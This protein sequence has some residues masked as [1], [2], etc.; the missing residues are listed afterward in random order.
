MVAGRKLFFE[1]T[2][3]SC[4]RC[5][6]VG[7]KFGEATGGEVGPN[8][9]NVAKDKDR[10]YLLES[11]CIPDATI[12][13]GFETV[14][15]ADDSGQVYTGIILAESEELIDLV[16]ADG[17]KRRIPVEQIVA[18]RKGTS[19]MPNDLVKQMTLRELRDLVAF[20]ASLQ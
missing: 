2:Q 18:R 13:K 14:V 1:K 17:A 3:L 6:T 7:F 16:Q 11:I 20:L 19:A 8:L 15:L 4:V 10:Q 12:A 5:H 9:T